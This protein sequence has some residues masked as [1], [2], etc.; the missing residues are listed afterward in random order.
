MKNIK[1]LFK[2]INN[3]ISG[4]KLALAAGEGIFIFGFSDENGCQETINFNDWIKIKISPGGIPG[5]LRLSTELVCQYR[6]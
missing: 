4:V 6:D 3:L 2:I 5:W 1:F